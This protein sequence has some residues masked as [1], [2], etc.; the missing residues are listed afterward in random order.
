MKAT[1]V[2]MIAVALLASSA[3]MRTAAQS[4]IDALVKKCEQL[5]D[6]T[7]NRVSKRDGNEKKTIISIS[8]PVATNQA[9][10]DEFIAAFQEEEESSNHAESKTSITTKKNK[11]TSFVFKSEEKSYIFSLD[12][13]DDQANT[14][15][16]ER[17]AS[18][19]IITDSR[20]KEN[21]KKP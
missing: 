1:K 8:I 16:V 10:I 6:V 18:I 21:P 5:E 9:L 4:T 17:T 11:V 3:D 13:E 20:V 15:R 14:P 12:D 2:W 19:A 7:V